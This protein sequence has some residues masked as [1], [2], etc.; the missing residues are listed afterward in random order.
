MIRYRGVD[1]NT[2]NLEI[3]VGFIVE[4]DQRPADP[5]IQWGELP[6]GR[7]VALMHGGPYESLVDSTAALHEWA[8][9]NRMVLDVEDHAKVTQWGCRVE[10]YLVAPA[11][12]ITT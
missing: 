10:R 8:R 3:E 11:R 12:G 2:G 5:R 4:S 6:A 1:Y 9:A 7:Y